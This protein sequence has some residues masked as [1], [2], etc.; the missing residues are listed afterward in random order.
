MISYSVIYIKFY[1]FI[2]NFELLIPIFVSLRN[3][4]D[5]LP[6]DMLTPLSDILGERINRSCSYDAS[7]SE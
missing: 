2:E 6:V 5:P 3:N 4:F 7:I 1:Y